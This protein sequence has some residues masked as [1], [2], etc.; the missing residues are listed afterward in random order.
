MKHIL[1]MI[2][3]LNRGGRYN[4]VSLPSRELG[5]IINRSQQATSNY[6]LEL[7]RLG[8][9]ERAKVSNSRGLNIK[10]TNKGY[11]ELF[12]L[13]QVLRTALEGVRE[14]EFKG[15]IIKGMGEGSYYI[16]LEGYKKQFID[17]LG[18]EPYPGTLNIKL[19]DRY[20]NVKGILR[21]YP[22]IFIEGF[23]DEKRTYGWVR[24]YKA[25]IEG[26]E[27]A[28]LILERTHYDDSVIEAIAPVRIMDKL[29]IDYGSSIK[30][31]VKLLDA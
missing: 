6:L 20:K 7:E 1:L 13:Y 15:K 3:L 30:V 26:I 5:K 14:L 10:V 18:F 11:E 12:N 24:C 22:G 27:G 17:K 19:D 21:M 29:K 28:V 9:I 8:Y 23:R 16:S 25:D 31:R 2:E 4:Y